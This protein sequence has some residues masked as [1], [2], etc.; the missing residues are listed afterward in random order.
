[1]SRKMMS[2]LFLLS[3]VVL[4][5]AAVSAAPPKQGQKAGDFELT[6]LDGKKVRLSEQLKNGPA[7]VVMLR[8]FPGYQC[9]LC[10]RQVGSLMKAA[11]E[12]AKHKAQVLLVYPGPGED[13]QSRAKEFMRDTTLPEGFVLLIDP[14]Y[15]MTNAWNLRWDAKRETAYPSTF[16]IGSDG[17][18]DFALVSKT[19]GGRSKTKDVVKA[20]EGAAN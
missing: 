2:V 14:D 10:T 8:G 4:A 3:G 13:L 9:P 16:V 17:I 20:V 19:H 11:P 5:V 6:S 18:I 15:T 12:F 1:M 7:V